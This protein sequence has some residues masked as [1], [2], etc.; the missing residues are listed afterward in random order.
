MTTTAGV[1]YTYDG[2]GKRVKKSNGKLY[3]YGTSSDSLV[4]TDLA[5]NN[6][7]DFVF[8]SGKRIAR[9]DPAGIISYFFSDHLGS[10]RVVTNAT[11]SIVEDSDFYPF[12]GERVVTAS[13]DNNYLFTGKERDAESGLDFFIARYYSSNLGRF[14]SPDEFTGGAAV[15]NSPN[16]PLPLGPLPYAD[17]S[18]PQSLNKYTYTYNNPIVY[19]DPSG[20]ISIPSDI[21]PPEFDTGGCPPGAILCEE[22]KKKEKATQKPPDPDAPINPFSG[23]ILGKVINFAFD[24]DKI[25]LASRDVRDAETAIGKAGAGGALVLLIASNLF[26]GTGQAASKAEVLVYKIAVN[27]KTIYVGITKDLLRRAKNHGVSLQDLAVIA[28]GLTRLRARGVEQALIEIHGLAK[29]GGQLLNKINSIAKNNPH[30][31]KAVEYGK[32]YLESIRYQPD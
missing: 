27:G 23:G 28:E 13:T 26:P 21:L 17:I 6:A 15:V 18:N 20:H 1:T 19:V 7:T 24:G 16:D 10:S 25:A 4:E 5:G 8:F 14:L 32:K 29:H 22:P 3:W 9:R 11:G 30:Y 31:K 12:G 2:D